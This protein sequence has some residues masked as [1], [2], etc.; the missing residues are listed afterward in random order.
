MH[1]E[2][3]DLGL[4]VH[5]LEAGGE[6]QCWE[7]VLPLSPAPVVKWAVLRLHRGVL[8]RHWDDACKEE[9]VVDSGA[10]LSVG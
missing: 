9:S 4:V 7:D 10:V 1:Q 2:D 3:Q 6:K 5:W 8:Q